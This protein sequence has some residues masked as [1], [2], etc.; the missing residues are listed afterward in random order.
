VKII[1]MLKNDTFLEADLIAFCKLL[2][3]IDQTITYSKFAFTLC[4]QDIK[5]T[6][7]TSCLSQKRQTIWNYPGELAPERCIK[8]YESHRIV[9]LLMSKVICVAAVVSKQI[10]NQQKNCTATSI[11]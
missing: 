3:V 5:F 7:T 6:R 9:S 10:Q 2:V 1:V 4:L 11:V 8:T